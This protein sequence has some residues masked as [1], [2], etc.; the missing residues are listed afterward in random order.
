MLNLFAATAHHN[1]AKPAHLYVQQMN[2]LPTATH[3]C[4]NNS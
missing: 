4:M 1:Y 3:M 2:D